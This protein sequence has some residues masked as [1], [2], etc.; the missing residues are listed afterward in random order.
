M[1]GS[2]QP[3]RERRRTVQKEAVRR[4]LVQSPGFVS[5]TA[6]HRRLQQQGSRVGL[7]TVYRQLTVLAETGLAD[8]V[9]APEGQ[10]YRACAPTHGHHHHLICEDCGRAVEI[11]PPSEEWIEEAARRHGYTL[12]R[13]VVEVFGRCAECGAER[14]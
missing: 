6:L 1:T 7:A 3:P 13:H 10:L 14:A 9:T 12:T 4:A 5:A 8:T 11:A 2:A